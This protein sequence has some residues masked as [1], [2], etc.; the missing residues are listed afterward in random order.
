MPTQPSKIVALKIEL[1]ELGDLE[2]TIVGLIAP[3]INPD[4][5]KALLL[6]VA[7]TDGGLDAEDHEVGAELTGYKILSPTLPPMVY[8]TVLHVLHDYVLDRVAEMGSPDDWE[9]R[10]EGKD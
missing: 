4:E 2:D 7:I 10:E 8:G 6:N 3:F 9:G 1:D 5:P